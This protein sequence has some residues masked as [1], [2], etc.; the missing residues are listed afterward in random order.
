MSTF[1]SSHVVRRSA[2]IASA[3]LLCSGVVPAAIVYHRVE[4]DPPLISYFTSNPRQEIDLDD[5]GIFDFAIIAEGLASSLS[6]PRQ[7]ALFGLDYTTTGDIGS[8]VIPLSLGEEVGPQLP[9]RYGALAGFYSDAS[10][11]GPHLLAGAYVL[12]A[13]PNPVLIVI[14]NFILIRAYAGV[15][16]EIDGQT[17][18]GWIDLENSALGGG[19]EFKAYGWAYESEPNTPI[20]AGSVPEP[21][22][23]TLLVL[24]GVALVSRS[25][26]R[27]RTTLQSAA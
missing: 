5:D 14:G 18:Y 27:G 13:P 11:G 1:F 16:F 17:H 4:G 3:W 19:A 10:Q 23:A 21:S 6:A 26:A 24:G 25:R 8:K 20:V 7:A 2:L 12:G 9:M 22:L 15:Q